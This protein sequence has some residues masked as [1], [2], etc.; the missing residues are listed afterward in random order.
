[1]QK[2]AVVGSGG[3]GKSTLAR[4]MGAI[5]GLPVLHLDA[6]YW[7]PGWRPTPSGEWRR[8]QETIVQGDAWIIDGHYAST[9]DIRLRAAD[10]AVL[11]DYSRWLCLARAWK[12]RFAHRLRARPDMAPG[13]P[14]KIDL[15]FLLWIW[16]F[17]RAGKPRLAAH[18]AEAA[19]RGATVVR[20]TSPKQAALFLH[21][22]RAEAAASPARRPP[23]D[24]SGNFPQPF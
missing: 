21:S 5:L 19:A 15:A 13:C 1:M 11:L 8:I 4:Q 16:R 24:S 14:E 6:L 10:T 9:L 22:L 7:R 2:I 17:P 3:A 23:A 18:L 20:L 12:R